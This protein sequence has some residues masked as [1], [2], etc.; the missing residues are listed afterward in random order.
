MPHYNVLFL[1]TGNSARSIMAEAIMNRKGMPTFTAYSAGSHPSGSVRPEALSQIENAGLSTENF[2][3]ESWMSSLSRIP[4][5][6]ISSSRSAITQR[7]RSVLCGLVS[8]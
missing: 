4:P 6:L 7:T 5:R 3:S 1:C 2:R 8:P